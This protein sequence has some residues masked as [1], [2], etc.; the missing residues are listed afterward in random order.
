MTKLRI[1]NYQI[2]MKNRNNFK[3]DFTRDISQAS[4]YM[5]LRFIIEPVILINLGR[6]LRLKM[7][8]QKKW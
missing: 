1:V 7:D 6:N 4:P 5:V 3:I 8:W 2:K